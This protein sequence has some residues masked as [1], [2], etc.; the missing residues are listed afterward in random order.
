M[1]I[2]ILSEER[3]KP[4]VIEEILYLYAKQKN[5]GLA[6][7]ERP[8]K[9]TP[10]IINGIFQGTYLVSGAEIDGQPNVAIKIASGHSS[11]VDF[12]VYDKSENPPETDAKPV[13]IIEE[14]KTADTESRN[15]GIFQRASK[16]VFVDH[17]YP[18]SKKYML[19]HL[20]V[21]EQKT[22]TSTNTFGSRLLSTISVEI[23]GK[24]ITNLARAAFTSVTE[25]IKGRSE[26]R[27]PPAG[28]VPI[29]VEHRGDAIYISGRLHKSGGLSHDPNI[30]ALTLIAKGLRVLGWDKRIVITQHGLSQK[31][32]NGRNKFVL[33]ANILNIE[34]DG[35]KLPVAEMPEVYWAYDTR[36]E[37]LATILLSILSLNTPGLQPIY[38][39]H[40]GS[41]RGYLY[42]AG[43]D[44]FVVHKYVK[45]EKSLGNVNLPDLVIRD[46]NNK[47]IYI[48]E[49]KISAK[50]KDALDDIKNYGPF[51]T[52]L[53]KHYP[54]YACVRGVVLYGE[55][56][57]NPMVFFTLTPTGKMVL[58]NKK[59]AFLQ[60]IEAA[61][62][63]F[64][65][66]S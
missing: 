23:V 2:W 16:F 65:K 41:E 62:S 19:Y 57:E 54:E 26:V 40:A 47:T 39:N 45:E 36:S 58:D 60:N 50:I 52:Y 12:L 27:R 42:G 31:N 44:A 33:I 10:E 34:L 63:N 28:N 56:V 55:H 61:I 37:K 4:E 29:T 46:D 8:L 18:N 51:E 25:L 7:L 14:T 5:K 1:K 3:P 49:G 66:P 30:G 13:L 6:I 9:I 48:L 24:N 11:F 64:N 35:L 22:P 20:S 32:L 21:A 53:K 38:E 15:T 59:A 17:Y 43:D